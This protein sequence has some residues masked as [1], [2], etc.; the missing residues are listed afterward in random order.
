MSGSSVWADENIALVVNDIPL[1]ATQLNLLIG[2]FV[3]KGAKDD[4]ELRKRL[5]EELITREA[6]AQEALKLELD[7]SPEMLAALAN[8]KRDLLVNAFQM[9]Y[10]A[11]HPVSDEEINVLYEQQKSEAGDKE[12]RIRHILV[13]TEDEAK[14][15]LAALKRGARLDA[16]AREKSLDAASRAAGGDIGWQVPIMLVAPIRDLVR[17]LTKGQ[18]SDP[19]QSPFGWHVLKVEDVRTFAFPSFEKAEPALR[20]QLRTQAALQAISD[21]RKRVQLK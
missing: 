18:I 19:V 6:V 10:A 11:K 17:N 7:K 12:Y 8:A 1:P 9:D 14:A 5:T 2:S 3:A 21:I 4:D 16:L 13:K 20:E 15:I